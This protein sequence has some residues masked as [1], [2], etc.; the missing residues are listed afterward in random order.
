MSVNEYYYY[1]LRSIHIQF[2]H[3]LKCF[4][5]IIPQGKGRNFVKLFYMESLE[6]E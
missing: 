6:S 2:A 1:Y 3:I 5:T 4:D